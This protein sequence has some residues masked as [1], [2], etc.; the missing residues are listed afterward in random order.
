MNTVIAYI[1]DN[2]QKNEQIY[3]Q[4]AGILRSGGLVA[5]P[6]ET[7]YGLGADALT[8]E[9]ALKIYAAKGRPSDNPLIVHIADEAALYELSSE[10]N[11]WALNLA[12]HFWPGPL[13]MILKKKDIVPKSI[14]GGLE[15]VAIRMPSHPVARK[16]IA[17]SGV[18]VAAPSANTSGKPS[19]TRAKHVIHDMQGRIDMIIADDTVDIGVESTIVDIS[20]EV[21]MIL[22]PGYITK[23]QLESV[24]GQV[25]VDPAIMGSLADGVVPKAPG[26]KYRHYA[27]EAQMV[28]VEG[29][30]NI[31]EMKLDLQDEKNANRVI[32]Y[33]NEMTAKKQ[34]EGSKVGVMAS[35]ETAAQYTADVVIPVGSKHDEAS[36]ARDL[37]AALRQFDEEQVDIIFAESISTYD[38][39]LAV[40]NRLIKAAGHTIINVDDI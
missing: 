20:G 17:T 9:A 40:M 5:F 7:V 25:Q 39:G 30:G 27:P 2:E 12:K 38:V 31:G 3:N 33:I 36:A 13:T 23:A 29:A 37:Y 22:R 34:V 35:K 19:P 4:A 10:V 11:E 14:T 16:L 26:M 24:L 32:E 6:T 1:T 15:T 8:E 28:L 21:P 18:Y